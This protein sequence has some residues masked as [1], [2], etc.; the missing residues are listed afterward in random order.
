MVRSLRPSETDAPISL[1]MELRVSQVLWQ[2]FGIN[3]NIQNM[4]A[5]THTKIIVYVLPLM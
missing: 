4:P 5:G 2:G 1:H 3:G